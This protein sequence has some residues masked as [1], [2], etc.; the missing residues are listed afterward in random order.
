MTRLALRKT[1]LLTSTTSVTIPGKAISSQHDQSLFFSS[2]AA[3]VYRNVQG[4]LITGR[5]SD[6][7]CP[8]L[9]PVDQRTARGI[10]TNKTGGST[11]DAE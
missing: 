4:T 5:A 9:W 10:L 3:R 6:E 11:S 7:L 2:C 1:Q 8:C